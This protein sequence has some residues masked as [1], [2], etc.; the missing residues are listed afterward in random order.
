MARRIAASKNGV[1]EGPGL[2]G[3]MRFTP[4]RKSP[5]RLGGVLRLPSAA[6]TAQVRQRAIIN[7]GVGMLAVLALCLLAVALARRIEQPVRSLAAAARAFSR[8]DQQAY[9]EP[10]GPTELVDLARDFNTMVA[11]RLHA[12]TELQAQRQQLQTA[13]DRLDLAMQIAHMG[14]WHW[15]LR[16]GMVEGDDTLAQI[17]GTRSR[18]GARS[19][20]GVAP[21]RT[22]GRPARTQSAADRLPQG[23]ETEQFEVAQR[24][25]HRDG[26]WIWGLWRGRVTERDAQGRGVALMGSFHDITER[27]QAH[28]RLQLAASVLPMP[29]GHHHH[30]H[31]RHH[32]RRERH[33]HPHHRLFARRGHRQQPTHAAVGSPGP[34]FLC[35]HVA[36]PDHRGPLDG[37]SVEPPQERRTVCRNHHHQRRAQWAGRDNALRCAV[38]RHH[39]AQGER[40]QARTHC[41]LRRPDRPAQSCAA[42]RSAAA[43]HGTLP[44]QD[45]SLAVAFIDL[46]GFK[47]VND[48]HGH[49]QGDGLLVALAQ[50]L[51]SSLREGDTLSRMGGDEFVAVLS[52]LENTK[53]CE[54]V[55]ER[56]LHAAA[57]PV[58]L[59][60]TLFQV[61]ASIG[62]TLFPADG[63]E[64]DL[65]I[66]HA[67]QAMYQ[68]KQ[69][70]KNRY[71]LFDVE[72]DTAVKTQREES[73]ACARP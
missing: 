45:Q 68:A 36:Q 5:N 9:A 46:D 29:R 31:A 63:V 59:G 7:V 24:L 50:R 56:M 48:L 52:D 3:T 8:G 41:A 51:Q 27:R 64:P 12:E 33:V 54:P 28:E 19:H 47:A 25:R 32:H 40:T 21:P 38:H 73:R 53:D 57:D 39:L 43:S 70:G 71:H 15:D 26:H 1:F 17:L 69:A 23:R 67:D 10:Y 34:R 35:L 22:P 6:I 20:R 42:G 14:L 4:P 37:R 2:E 61:S 11:D 30:R 65:L 60:D 62:V 44:T 49:E 58:R 16:T 66:R 72:H 18:Y 55:L 13:K